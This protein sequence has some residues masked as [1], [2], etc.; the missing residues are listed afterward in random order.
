MVASVG[1]DGIGV[2]AQPVGH[3][4]QDAVHFARFFLGQAHQLVVEVDGF[5]RLDEQRV[6]AGA[7]AVDHA[8]QLAA[9]PGDERHHEALIADGDE[10]LLQH[11]FFAVRFEEA[12]ERF[13]DALSSAA[14]CRGAGGRA[15]RWR[16]RRRCH[17]AGS[18]HRDRSAARGNRRW[19][20][21]VRPSRGN[22]SAS[23]GQH[24]I[25]AS[26]ARSSRANTSKISL[27]SRLAP[28]MRSLWTAAFGVGQAAEIDP[29]GRAARRRLRTR[30]QRADIRWLRR[31]RP[32]PLPAAPIRVRLDLFQFA[33]SQRAG[34]KAPDQLP[35]R[36]EFE[37]FGGG[38]HRGARS[39]A[40]GLLPGVTD[41]FADHAAEDLFQGFGPPHHVLA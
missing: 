2:A 10:L 20:A 39:L 15:P 38:F 18:C 19:F 37:N 6:A 21:P 23:R 13:L 40:A 31:L 4:A 14:R 29:D 34:D 3:L 28:S 25:L 35:E 30:G 32:D 41:F 24:A 9:L 27:G 26:A 1:A 17:R 36:F 12:L 33:P 5:E 7:G 8:I 11:A 16:G 22:R